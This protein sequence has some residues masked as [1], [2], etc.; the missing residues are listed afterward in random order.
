MPRSSLLGYDENFNGKLHAELL[1]REI[2]Y[3]FE[4][5]KILI[6]DWRKQYDTIQPHSSPG[7]RPPAP[8]R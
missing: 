4:E 2:F 8:K 3:T 1:N 7:Y 6:E 5:A